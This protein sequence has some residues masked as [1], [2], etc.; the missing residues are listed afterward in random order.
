MLSIF[1]EIP[2][3]TTINISQNTQYSPRNTEENHEKPQSEY[4][5]FS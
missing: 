3:K 1:L 2:G 5:I 4:P